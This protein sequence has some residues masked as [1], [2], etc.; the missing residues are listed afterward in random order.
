MG[1]PEGQLQ[2]AGA[3]A[4]ERSNVPESERYS[5][6]QLIGKGG[7]SHVYR[8]WDRELEIN[9]AIKLL[10]RGGNLAGHVKKLRNEVLVS[11]ALR[12][13]CICPVHDIY[14]GSAGFG[15][16]MD[17]LEGCDLK[18]WLREHKDQ[19]RD[20]FD[21][22]FKLLVQLSDALSLAHARIVHRDLKPSNVYLHD[23]DIGRPLILDF[24]L[25]TLDHDPKRKSRSG[26]PKYMAPEQFEGQADAR[27]DL[28]ALGIIAYEVM[29]GGRHPYRAEGQ[30]P[31]EP[32]DF[33]T[34]EEPTAPSAFCDLIPEPLDRLILQLVR[35]DPGERPQAASEVHAALLAIA[36]QPRSAPATATVPQGE[37]TSRIRIAGGLYHVGSPASCRFD[38]EKPMRQIELSDFWL[39]T[40][41]V[42]NE[43]YREYARATGRTLPPYE[44]DP[45]F[46][47][48]DHPVVMVSW[49]EAT[50]Y[51]EW[52]GGRLPTELE[53]EVA[54]KGGQKTSDYPWGDDQPTTQHANIDNLVGVTTPVTAY[55]LGRNALGLWEMAGNV[56]EWCLDSWNPNYYRGLSVIKTFG[57]VEPIS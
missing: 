46:G 52:L 48:D 22:R 14:E 5:D 25:S 17:L 54:A 26:T 40:Y 16:V 35:P 42:T 38:A 28:F 37:Q 27:S 1:R 29:T 6:W 36:Q 9:L 33:T 45:I 55:P 19:L 32:S 10:R 50:T 44:S 49:H 23:G 11:R 34:D 4:E 31:A 12:H 2:P 15:V 39:S 30:G 8:V 56:W 20:T 43:E 57:T 41:P 47:R 3:E 18:S 7:F 13:P 24:G 53:W 51:A 21:E